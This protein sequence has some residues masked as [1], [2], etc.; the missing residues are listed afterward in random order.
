MIGY[1]RLLISIHLPVYEISL[2]PGAD[3]KSTETEGLF[4]DRL[5]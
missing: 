2:T 5:R 3:V 1:S 4:P